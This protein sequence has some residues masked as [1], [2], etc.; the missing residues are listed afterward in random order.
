M[1]LLFVFLENFAQTEQKAN[2]IKPPTNNNNTTTQ[3]QSQSIPNNERPERS[4]DQIKKERIDSPPT[5]YSQT[6]R[7]PQ[8]LQ[9]T[10]PWGYSGIDLMNTGAAFWQNYSGECDKKER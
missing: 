5:S 2:N 6:V 9:D 7:E 8:T 4:T 1:S 3:Q 10:K